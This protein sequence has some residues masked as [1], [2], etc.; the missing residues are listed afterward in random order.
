[1][2]HKITIRNTSLT[3]KNKNLYFNRYT[4][5]NNRLNYN[6]S[7]CKVCL[8]LFSLII[9]KYI[10]RIVPHPNNGSFLTTVRKPQLSRNLLLYFY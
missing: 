3:N 9:G 2:I 5:H 4:I 7:L 6:L 1:M 10:F 8:F